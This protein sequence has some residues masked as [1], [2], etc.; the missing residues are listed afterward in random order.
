MPPF[1]VE[2][3]TA[4]PFFCELLESVSFAPSGRPRV[5]VVGCGEGHEAVYL[6]ERLDAVVDAIDVELSDDD[7]AAGCADV[8][9]QLASVLEL[10]F[11]DDRFDAVF[12]HHVIEHVDDP[13]RSLQ[14]IERV[15]RPGGWL[16]VGTPNRHR[17]VSSVGAHKQ[18]HWEASL[19]NK[20]G[21][22]LE[23]WRRRLTGTF[24]NEL[25]AHA[26]FSRGELDRMLAVHFT[27]RRWVTREYL[28]RKYPRGFQGAA[29]R[30]ATLPPLAWCCA[31]SIYVLCR[32]N[33]LSS[34]ESIAREQRGVVG[35]PM[36]E[37]LAPTESL[38]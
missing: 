24:R 2:T 6:Q 1:A 17:L 30:F 16:F 26:G 27:E 4:A 11:A 8:H 7:A 18:R 14:E 3:H 9:V 23:D 10:P 13:A 20:L 36:V 25:G 31:P 38:A 33:E 19:A 12:Y 21:D 5:L 28:C 32:A 29:A 22:N 15:L 34:V 37:V 35:L